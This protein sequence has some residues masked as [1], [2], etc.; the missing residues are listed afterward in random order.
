MPCTIKIT[1][2]QDAAVDLRVDGD[3]APAVQFHEGGYLFMTNTE[4]GEA[5]CCTAHSAH[6]ASSS[7]LPC[8][9]YSCAVR[10]YKDHLCPLQATLRS[11]HQVQLDA[12]CHWMRL[13]QEPEGL[14]MRLDAHG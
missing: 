2:R 12:G 3:D 14:E 10:P 9:S 13:L 7:L 1:I 4:S 6:T 5:T 8:G 11:N